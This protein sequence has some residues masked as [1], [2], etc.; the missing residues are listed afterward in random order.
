MDKYAIPS[1]SRVKDCSTIA[2]NWPDH[3][4]MSSLTTLGNI[5]KRGTVRVCAV[6]FRG[7][8]RGDYVKG[9][10]NGATPEIEAEIVKRIGLHFKI[11]PLKVEYVWVESRD[12]LFSVLE[13][14]ECDY[15][16]PIMPVGGFTNGVRRAELWRPSCSVLADVVA[17]YVKDDLNVSSFDQFQ[18]TFSRPRIGCVGF[19]V[20]Q[21]CPQLIIDSKCVLVLSEEEAYAAL[22]DGSIDTFIG[23]SSSMNFAHIKNLTTTYFMSRAAWFRRERPTRLKILTEDDYNRSI[24]R[25]NEALALTYEAALNTIWQLTVLDKI[26]N[27]YG[28]HRLDSLVC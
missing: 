22:Q 25:G 15:L 1:D 5:S 11:G 20:Q 17:L 10:V 21:L 24:M 14:G 4:N 23:S 28:V 27:R 9:N 13:Q 18:A 7:G 6:E 16:F 19:A 8:S 12:D 26:F 3:A 2:S